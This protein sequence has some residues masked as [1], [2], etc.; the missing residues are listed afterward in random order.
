MTG[1]GPCPLRERYG[2]A[3]WARL[4]PLSRATQ[5]APR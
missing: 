5:I 1:P 3:A 4:K 2:V